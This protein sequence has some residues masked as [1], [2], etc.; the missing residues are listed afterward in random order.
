MGI[1]ESTARGPLN[2]QIAADLRE[3]IASGRLAPGALLPS[4]RELVA[5]YETTK[6]TAG[7]AIATLRAEGLVTTQPGRGV[8]VRRSRPFLRLAASRYERRGDGL[9]PVRREASA[10]GWMD[11]CKSSAPRVTLANVGLAERLGIDVGE[12]VSEVTYLWSADGEPVQ[13][14]TQ[15]EP[16]A[17]TRGTPIEVPVDDKFGNLDVIARF[18]SI[19]IRV[20]K[21]TEVV[22]SRMPEPSE[23]TDLELPEGV[24]ILHIQ[25][26]HVADGR[27]VETADITVRSD[28]FA[29]ENTQ[30]VR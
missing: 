19:G 1:M 7:K 16:L 10:G 9:S 27:P 20:D 14:A 5:K 28:R 2:Q 11:G 24:P 21:V 30:D 17:L 25:R 12:P 6:S 22:T 3:E 29:I 23:V 18:D 26:T 13:I 4:E 15:W 8:F